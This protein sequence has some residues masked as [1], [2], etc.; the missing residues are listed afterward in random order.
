[1]AERVVPTNATARRQMLTWFVFRARRVAEHSLLSDQDRFLA[2]CR[3]KMNITFVPNGESTL[4]ISLPDEEAFE[5]LAGRC[6]PFLMRS[7]DLH[8]KKVLDALRTH[9]SADPGRLAHVDA[10]DEAWSKL[11]PKSGATLGLASQ[12]GAA[13]G[14]LG[15]LIADTTLADAWLYCDFGHGDINAVERVG[16]HGL[17]SRYS[18]AVLLI[19]NIARVAVATLNFIR[20][21]C[22]AGLLELDPEA[23]TEPVLAR[24]ERTWVITAMAT[25]PV[26]TPREDLEA[27]L[28]DA[29]G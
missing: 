25:G 24:P 23:F 16:E 8:F 17:D 5:S 9:L 20:N 14:P 29:E 1:M 19:T 10:L 18:A 3:G 6:R 27:A 12:V 13:D 28:R 22:N 7:D 11:D 26:G 15:A 21:C 4:K 2:W